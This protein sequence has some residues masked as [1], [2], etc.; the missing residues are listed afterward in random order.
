V[1]VLRHYEQTDSPFPN[2]AAV[3]QRIRNN[4]VPGYQ[5][6]DGAF[7]RALLGRLAPAMANAQWLEGRAQQNNYN[8]FTAVHV[9]IRHLA[10]VGEQEQ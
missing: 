10:D 7:A 6:A 8:P 4:H 2:C 1:W 3:V 9:L 5:K